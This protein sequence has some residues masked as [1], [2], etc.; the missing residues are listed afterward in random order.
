[1]SQ[2]N[3]SN[4][5][6]DV[7]VNSA[8]KPFDLKDE[9]RIAELNAKFEGGKEQKD[10]QK[11]LS[12]K[13][14]SEVEDLL[15]KT[16]TTSAEALI[17]DAQ[18]KGVALNIS[19]II[20]D[21]IKSVLQDR[22]STTFD[23]VDTVVDFAKKHGVEVPNLQSLY[24]QAFDD[25]AKGH[26]SN[27]TAF[28]KAVKEKGI[29]VNFDAVGNAQRNLIASYLSYDTI[30]TDAIMDVLKF[31]K[32]NNIDLGDVKSIITEARA[33]IANTGDMRVMDLNNLLA[34]L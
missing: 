22:S 3:F 17:A 27:M 34:S 31:A 12:E 25:R 15:W 28:L 11:K 18:E 16:D 10:E 1:M 13:T 33:K 4:S 5:Q 24:Q 21:S 19:N 26:P 7:K 29:E 2:E 20:N 30:Q 9:A 32:E 8:P 23:K 6:E 14:S